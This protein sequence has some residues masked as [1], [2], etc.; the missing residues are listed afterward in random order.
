MVDPKKEASDDL[1]ISN[2]IVGGE[3]WYCIRAVKS[4]QYMDMS[5]VGGSI[6]SGG[7]YSVL[8]SS[9]ASCAPYVIHFEA[10]IEGQV[11][12]LPDA[13]SFPIE[14]VTIFWQLGSVQ[15]GNRNIVTP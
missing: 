4:P 5:L 13:G 12:T 3:Y 14:D 11:I 2:L 9:L 8:T 7:S 6:F 1:S 10:S 15:T